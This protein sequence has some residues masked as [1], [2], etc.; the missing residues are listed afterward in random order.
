MT[1]LS[2][3]AGKAL[4]SALGA[5]HAAVW[6]YGLANAFAG[7]AR[8]HAAINDAMTQHRR[9]RDTAEQALRDAAQ[10]PPPAQP[11]YDVGEPV[12]DQKSAIELLVKAENDCAI[13]WRSVLENC[14]DPALRGTA[15]D[16]LTTA[17]TR[18]T[19]WRL[20]I[21]RQPAAQPFPGQP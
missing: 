6:V 8:V 11:A 15:L 3:E 16:G 1:E 2:E 5:E 13:G 19:R 21:D 7:E 10:T 14:E 18:A 4:R 12:G 17:A 20:T 9:L